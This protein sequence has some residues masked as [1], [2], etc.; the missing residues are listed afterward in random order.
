MREITALAVKD[1]RILLRDRSGFFFVCFFPLI[2]A[3]FF[4]AIFSGGGGGQGIG[5]Y[6]VDEDNSE[7]SKTFIA[8]LE[9]AP[10]LRVTLSTREEATGRVRKGRT[11]A[12]LIVP[13]GFGERWNNVLSGDPPEIELGVDPGK[14]AAAGLLQGTLLRYASSRFEEAF[15]G[16]S[17]TGGGPN[18]QP[19]VIRNED[20]TVERVI[21]N[22]AYAVS[23]PQGI[24]WAFI[25]T[26]AAFGVSLVVERTRG[27]LI[28]L[29]MAPVNRMQILC[30]KALACYITTVAVASLLL[31]VAIVFFGVRPTSYPL[32]VLAV[33]CGAVGFVGIMMLVSVLGKTEQSA[34]G[35]GWA[36]L[37]VMSMT[38]G[39]MI[40]LMIMPSWMQ[41]VSN[42]SPVKW[43]VL[44]I[45]G[46][47]WRRFS[48]EEMLL[49]CGII[50][51]TGI[52][53]FSLGVKIFSFAQKE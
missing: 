8:K 33:L 32:L 30:G 41:F 28:R 53:F 27:T 49:P 18:L 24:I 3:V 15:G 42:F 38:G 23:F 47:I 17:A 34:G 40:P 43:L 2:M 5:V 6:L 48:F 9:E 13:A 4:G 14:T 36:L 10:E 20:V 1:L 37:L 31:L 29:R 22:N 26:A 11:T 44:G 16:S 19:V 21:P 52:V 25:G 50:A 35:I 39:G 46:A 45:E 51:G 7:I 12:Y